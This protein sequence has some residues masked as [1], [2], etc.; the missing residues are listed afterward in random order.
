MNKNTV[1]IFGIRIDNLSFQEAVDIII[2]KIKLSEL[3]EFIVTPN[4]HHINLLQKDEYFKRIYN[5]AFLVLPDGMSLIYVSKIF[6]RNLK[7]RVNGT[8]LFIELC[9]RCAKEKLKVFFLGGRIGAAKQ[10]AEILK[11]QFEGLMVAG[12]YC[13]NYGFENNID[14]LKYINELIINSKPHILFVGLG[15]PKQEKW[16]YE[17][18]KQLKVPISIGIGVSFEFIAGMVSRAPAWVQNIGFEWLYRLLSEPKRLWRRY[19]IGNLEFLY[20]VIKYF[21]KEKTIR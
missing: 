12:T 3:P 14:E 2:E 8:N 10:A 16:M 9:S 15:A 13:P 11:N 19:L 5:S 17:F 4:A 18:H 7:E 1:D 20:Y 6:R 21:V